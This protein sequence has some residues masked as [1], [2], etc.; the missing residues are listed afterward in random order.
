LRETL[1]LNEKMASGEV[2][3]DVENQQ[4]IGWA[5]DPYD[6][7][8]VPDFGYNLADAPEYDARFPQHPLSRLRRALSSIESSL[9]ID[10][11]SN[12]LQAYVR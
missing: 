1:V 9:S 4:M 6:A 3:A 11:S 7:N 5:R 2:K 8:L 10:R 12:C